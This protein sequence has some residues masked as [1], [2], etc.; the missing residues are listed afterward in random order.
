MRDWVRRIAEKGPKSLGDKFVALILAFL[1]LGYRFGFWVRQI[2]FEKDWIKRK[3]LPITVI[4][5]GNLTWGGTGKTPFVKFLASRLDLMGKKVLI[6]TRGYS[7]DEVR[8][9]EIACPQAVIGVGKNR[10][11]VALKKLSREL[12]D[13]AVLDDGFQHGELYRDLDIVLI[14]GICPFGQGHLIPWGSLREPL[15]QLS[16]G[17]LFVITHADKISENQKSEIQNVLR[18]YA[19]NADV[20]EAAHVPVRLF[21]AKDG[22]ELETGFIR[23]KGLISVSGIGFPDSFNESLQSLGGEVRRSF[24]FGDHYSYS[25]KELEEVRKL[26]DSSLAQEIVVTEKDYLRAPEL[27]TEILDPLVLSVQIKIISGEKILNDRLH[28]LLAR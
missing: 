15:S 27:L 25:S 26:K 14:N 8:E 18:R 21:R 12:P 20:I 16:R 7:H 5:V 9:Y 22:R 17:Q 10:Y 24:E 28:R 4:S 2:Y 23:G 6:L 19:P 13:I 3:R 11:D 1:S